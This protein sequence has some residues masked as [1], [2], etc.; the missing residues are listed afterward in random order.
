[1]DLFN[2]E[3]DLLSQVEAIQIDNNERISK[4]DKEHC[5][6]LQRICHQTL[7]QLQRSHEEMFSA[8][9]EYI[10][11]GFVERKF[12]RE[13]ELTKSEW[14]ATTIEE[15]YRCK[16]YI[17]VIHEKE[18]RKLF[19][20]TCRM[21]S[22]DVI[23]Y[24]NK[25]YGITVENPNTYKE[26]SDSKDFDPTFRPKYDELVDIVIA[27]LGGRTFAQTMEDEIYKFAIAKYLKDEIEIKGN[28]IVINYFVNSQY[29]SDSIS[30]ETNTRLIGLIDAIYYQFKGKRYTGEPKEFLNNR[31]DLSIGCTY[32]CIIPEIDHFK[33]YK[34][35][36]LEVKF[37]SSTDAQKFYTKLTA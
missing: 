36:K 1:M 9:K 22:Y 27:H 28:K 17:P 35:R 16:H 32:G 23:D 26:R 5:E 13:Y 2:Q 10:D 34:N 15:K 33:L 19:L 11:S 24:F 18:I 6:Y 21:F 12:G 8:S 20:E 7:D 30:Y 37:K 14:Y 29:Y 31:G 25:K 4:E 3:L